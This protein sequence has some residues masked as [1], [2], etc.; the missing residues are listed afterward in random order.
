MVLKFVNKEIRMKGNTIKE[1]IGFVEI[2]AIE[3]CTVAVFR[4]EALGGLSNAQSREGNALSYKF[5]NV[6]GP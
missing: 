1:E 4:L 3:S 6:P 2:H 5:Q